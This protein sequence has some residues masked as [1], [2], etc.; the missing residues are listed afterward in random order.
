MHTKAFLMAMCLAGG[1][2]AQDLAVVLTD[3]DNWGSRDHRRL[4]QAYRDAGYDV[5]DRRG[6]ARADVFAVL[7][8]AERRMKRADRVILHVTA[9]VATADG[10][11][12][13]YAPNEGS[14][15]TGL[16]RDA[17][18]LNYLL[19]LA[20]RHPGQVAVFL[21]TE[22]ELD[23][24][25]VPQ[26]VF[27]ASGS[28]TELAR[29]VQGQFLAEGRTVAQAS[30]R[31][32]LTVAGFASPNIGFGPEPAPQ[33]AQPAQNTAPQIGVVERTLWTLAEQNPNEANLR[34]YLDRFPQGVFAAEAKAKLDEIERNK[35]DP[36][37]AAEQALA[38]NRA[39]RRA[40]QERLTILGYDTRGVDGIFGRGSRA[41]ITAW[42]KDE[43]LK[44]SG[45]LNADQIELLKAR[46]DARSAEIAA[47]EEARKRQAELADIEFW[48]A[49]GS[50]GLAPDLRAYLSRYPEGIYAREARRKLEPFE[51]EE[52]RRAQATERADWDQ[53]TATD[54]ASAYRAYLAKYPQGS[55]R[56]AANARIAALTQNSNTNAQAAEYKKIEDALGLNSASRA[57]IEQRI[58]MLRY[59]VGAVDGTLDAQARKAIRAFQNRSG[60][61]ET[62][63]LTAQTLQRLIIASSQ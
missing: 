16:E 5:L 33:A 10:V 56:D 54:S 31:S 15:L 52:R 23:L 19:G 21:G 20:S 4:T 51:E 28:A 61:P 29:S 57:L 34:A 49:T 26:G 46:A 58:K 42:Q 59:D 14:A 1:A 50:S 25:A 22:A 47:E 7:D 32:D 12:Y 36:D 13:V 6:D 2:G 8:D 55:F 24:D 48:R 62:G 9:D 17:I 27:V 41:A 60:L 35:V 11:S 40:V 38:L 53:A 45:Y 3:P 63:Y 44:T 37:V 18:S 43:R 30:E 39:A